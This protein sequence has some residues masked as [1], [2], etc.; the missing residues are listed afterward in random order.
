MDGGRE[1][2]DNM[3]DRIHRAIDTMGIRLQQVES[4]QIRLACRL[5]LRDG[6]GE[7]GAARSKTGTGSFSKRLVH[8]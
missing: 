4:E 3:K 2:V 7:A 8:R 1:T 5:Q 6:H